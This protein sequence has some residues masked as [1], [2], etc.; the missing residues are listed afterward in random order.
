MRLGSNHLV[1]G[2]GCLLLGLYGLFFALSSYHDRATW[3]DRLKSWPSAEGRVIRVEELQFSTSDGSRETRQRGIVRFATAGGTHSEGL[4]FE[5]DLHRDE[6]V[7]VFYEPGAVYAPNGPYQG[8]EVYSDKFLLQR[9]GGH[10]HWTNDVAFLIGFILVGL[11]TLELYRY[12]KARLVAAFPTTLPTAEP[13]ALSPMRAP[14]LSPAIRQTSTKRFTNHDGAPLAP[15]VEFFCAAPEE[16]GAILSADST[17]RRGGQPT[18]FRRRAILIGSCLLCPPLVVAWAILGHHSV[19]FDAMVLA[20]SSG[21]FFFGT[22]MAITRTRFL[23]IV[24]YVGTQGVSR[25][26]LSRNRQ[27]APVDGSLLFVDAAVLS[28]S[29]TGVPHSAPPETAYEFKWKDSA[30]RVVY[31]LEGR[32]RTGTAGGMDYRFAKAA[33]ASWSL[34][35][36]ERLTPTLAKTGFLEFPLSGYDWVRVGNGYLEFCGSGAIERCEAADFQS[37]KLRNGR[38]T[39][40]HRDASAFRREGKYTF[41]LQKCPNAATFLLAVRKLAGWKE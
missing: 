11:A 32:F 34:H 28:I 1:R 36:F 33:E 5:E 20:G 7:K 23:Q 27:N 22:A 9:A 39:A 4:L 38:F 10:D 19:D 12:S 16:I 15:D 40:T 2:I 3:A 35:L 13:G 6:T 37:F 26:V 24:T 17:L 18:S 29:L 25:H 41:D 14:K 21:V 8:R 31:R 30:G